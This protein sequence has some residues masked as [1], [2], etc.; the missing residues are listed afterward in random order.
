MGQR[1]QIYIAF[2]KHG[3]DRNAR[4]SND[5]ILIARYYQW[6]FGSRM[7]SRAAGLIEWLSEHK[8]YLDWKTEH[9]SRIS[10]INFDFKDVVISQDILNEYANY[11]EGYTPK[12]FIFESQDNNDGKLFI[13]I[14]QDGTIKYAFTDCDI[15]QSMSSLDYMAWGGY[16]FEEEYGSNCSKNIMFISECATLMTDDELCDFLETTYSNMPVVKGD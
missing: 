11:G 9:I 8:D 7:V 14:E 5:R 6:N 3:V 16:D 2:N 10:D 12:D 4:T 13:S 15:S 1:S